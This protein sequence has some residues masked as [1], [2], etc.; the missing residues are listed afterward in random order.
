MSLI[1]REIRLISIERGYI[2]PQA[3]MAVQGKQE[4]RAQGWQWRLLTRFR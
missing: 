1:F 3:R 4:P 2:A